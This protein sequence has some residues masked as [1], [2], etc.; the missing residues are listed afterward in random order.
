MPKVSVI[1]PVYNG[2]RYIAEAI[3]SVLDQTEHDLELLV[4]DDASS[5]RTLEVVG[6]LARR[7]ARLR[8]VPRASNSGRPARPKNEGIA[9]RRG[10]FIC[11]LDH[12]DKYERTKIA[13]MVKGLEANAHWVAAFHDLKYTDRSGSP[14]PG[15]YL[16]DVNFVTSA[17]AYLKRLDDS[18]YETSTEFFKFQSLR[19]AALHTQSV[20]IRA[21]RFPD[22]MVWFDERFSVCEDTDLWIRIGMSGPMGYLEEVLSY[23]RIHDANITRGRERFLR[24][25]GLLHVRNFERVGGQMSPDEV[26]Q[27]RRKI[28]ACFANL[29]YWHYAQY[30]LG[31]A[32]DAYSQALQWSLRASVALALSKCFLPPNLLKRLRRN[33][34]DH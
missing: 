32:R 23:Y 13:R 34:E 31:E 25:T 30:D 22:D 7:D 16:T 20:M 19:F 14:E 9:L 8:V 10:K 5:D 28:S 6:D 12:D 18:W 29:G 15:S 27:Y 2:V 33:R 11:F 26:R 1:M 21:E 4:V 24:D 17:A 3:A